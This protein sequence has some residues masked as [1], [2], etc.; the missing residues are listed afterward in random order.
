MRTGLKTGSGAHRSRMLKPVRRLP[1]KGEKLASGRE[2]GKRAKHASGLARQRIIE[3]NSQDR[4]RHALFFQEQIQGPGNA[5][6]AR[7]DGLGCYQTHSE[8]QPGCR[9]MRSFRA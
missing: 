5:S 9:A 1:A 6:I 8:K 4:R 3:K 2:P 7:F